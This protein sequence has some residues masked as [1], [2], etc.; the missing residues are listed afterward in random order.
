MTV[1]SRTITSEKF[2]FFVV[3][4]EGVRR[5]DFAYI[6]TVRDRINQ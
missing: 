2:F 1:V 5:K 3:V 4:F 6:F